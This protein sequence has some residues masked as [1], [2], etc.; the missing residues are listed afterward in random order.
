MSGFSLWVGPSQGQFQQH[1]LS[2]NHL[3]RG[4]LILK[5]KTAGLARAR[6][7]GVTL[8][9][10]LEAIESLR[11]QATDGVQ[12]RE[13]SPCKRHAKAKYFQ[14]LMCRS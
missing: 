14:Y 9:H 8:P 7:A 3:E 13:L 5:K 4:A 6:F 12:I 2:I 10:E 1:F 11:I